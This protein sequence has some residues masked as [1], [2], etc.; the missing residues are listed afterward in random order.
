MNRGLKTSST[1]N[2]GTPRTETYAYDPK[3]DYLTG[4]QY[5]DGQSNASPTWTYDGA[6]NRVNSGYNYG[7]LSRMTAAL[8]TTYQNDILGNRLSETAGSA[9]KSYTWDCLNRLTNFS[10]PTAVAAYEYRADG[11][12]TTKGVTTATGLTTDSYRYNGQMPFE[13]ESVTG[14]TVTAGLSIRF[15][16]KFVAAGDAPR[17]LHASR[18]LVS[19][20]VT[21]LSI[22]F[23]WKFVAAGDAPRRLHAS[24]FL[25]SKSVNGQS[26]RRGSSEA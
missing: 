15:G 23:G 10:S 14:S 7:N 26:I 21:G 1:F 13:D 8:G 22:R 4:A 12:R 17:R 25:V 3:L 24:R 6:G 11:L 9:T 5:N 16:W 20:S 2:S 18:F 19:K